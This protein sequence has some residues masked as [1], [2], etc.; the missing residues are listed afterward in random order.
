MLDEC[1]NITF[2]TLKIKSSLKE[3]K[4]FL[5]T[6]PSISIPGASGHRCLWIGVKFGG[7]RRGYEGWR[8]CKKGYDLTS[9]GGLKTISDE[10][11]G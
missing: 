7:G 4:V 1:K 9:L 11:M 10:K 6:L 8:R 5:S 3:L 2:L